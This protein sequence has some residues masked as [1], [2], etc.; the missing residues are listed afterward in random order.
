[1][2]GGNWKLVFNHVGHKQE[3]AD[4]E[5]TDHT[6][7]SG[8]NVGGRP[9]IVSLLYK[10]TATPT[11]LWPSL[12]GVL[13]CLNSSYMQIPPIM[14]AYQYKRFYSSSPPVTTTHTLAVGCTWELCLS[15]CIT[16]GGFCT[17]GMK[18]RT[19]I[20]QVSVSCRCQLEA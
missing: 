15:S 1:M 2:K 11:Y 20:A 19:G 17:K 12:T 7:G 16:R 13:S 8:N 18:N 5:I 4:R 10:Y 9:S 3:E 6:R 14:A